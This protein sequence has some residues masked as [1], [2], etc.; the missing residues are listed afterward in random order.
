MKKTPDSTNA[1]SSALNSLNYDKP[2]KFTPRQKRAVEALANGPLMREELDRRAGVSN[3]PNLVAQLHR[4]GISVECELVNHV[5]RD[6]RP[7]RPGRYSLTDIGRQEAERL[8]L[9]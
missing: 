8:G 1:K 7:C 2:I 6:G 9:L 3:G 5:D 4:K